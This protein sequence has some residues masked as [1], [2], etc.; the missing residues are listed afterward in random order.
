MSPTEPSGKPTNDHVL[1]STI[2]THFI[3]VLVLHKKH[4]FK[5]YSSAG[6]GIGYITIDDP[7]SALGLRVATAISK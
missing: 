7:T 3:H 6:P 4:I 2:S 1:F 5:V